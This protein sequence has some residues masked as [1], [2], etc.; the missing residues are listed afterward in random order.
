MVNTT[1]STMIDNRVLKIPYDDLREIVYE[2]IQTVS[3][4]AYY[5]VAW[6]DYE[7]KFD[8][9]GVAVEKTTIDRM[10]LWWVPEDWHGGVPPWNDS[11]IL[12]DLIPE[13]EDRL[14]Y[15]LS[16]S[17]RR[18]ELTERDLEALSTVQIHVTI[19]DTERLVMLFDIPPPKW[20]GNF[21][22]MNFVIPFIVFIFI[23]IMFIGWILSPFSSRLKL[24]LFW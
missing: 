12:Q 4:A 7:T 20:F 3:E 17:G 1:I 16:M 9:Q 24:E 10:E 8:L 18:L 6:T 22:N 14:T 15:W 2:S 23:I 19:A 5:S 13:L 11:Q 21:D